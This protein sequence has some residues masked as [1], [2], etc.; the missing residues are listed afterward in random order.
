MDKKLT[1]FENNNNQIPNKKGKI[2]NFNEN[3]YKKSTKKNRSSNSYKK[4]T[5]INRVSKILIDYS[6]IS[7]EAMYYYNIS[8][9]F[10]KFK[11][12]L[13]NNYQSVLKTFK[14]KNRYLNLSIFYSLATNFFKSNFSKNKNDFSKN[15][16]RANNFIKYNISQNFNNNRK[17]TSFLNKNSCLISNIKYNNHFNKS[18]LIVTLKY[19]LMDLPTVLFNII[20]MLIFNSIPKNFHYKKNKELFLLR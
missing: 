9:T 12:N 15:N 6:R 8:A 7:I 14:N 16:F 5:S 19:L 11:N 1:R 13:F 18:L 4:S 10:T 3:I 20:E 2:A 17:N